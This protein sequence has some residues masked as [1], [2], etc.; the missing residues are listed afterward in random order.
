[1]K[2]LRWLL[3]LV[4]LAAGCGYEKD[5]VVEDKTGDTILHLKGYEVDVRVTSLSVKGHSYLFFTTPSASDKGFTAI[6]DPDC[7]RCVKK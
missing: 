7:E 6:H 3:P 4:L 2:K 1:M 5:E